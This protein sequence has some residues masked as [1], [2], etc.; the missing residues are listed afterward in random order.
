MALSRI[1]SLILIA[2]L[3]VL[4]TAATATD[5]LDQKAPDAPVGARYCLKVEAVTGTRLETVMCLTRDDWARFDVDVD[6]EWARE[7][8]RVEA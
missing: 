4:A 5:T 7:G 2:P 6:R 8:V 1:P 3:T